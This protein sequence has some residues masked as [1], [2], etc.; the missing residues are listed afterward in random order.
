MDEIITMAGSVLYL[1]SSLGVLGWVGIRLLPD[2]YAQWKMDKYQIDLESNA[3][4]AI[5]D[6]LEKAQGRP[7]QIT[8]VEDEDSE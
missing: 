2:A 5:T 1:A 3:Y 7:I 6:A 4:I 8:I